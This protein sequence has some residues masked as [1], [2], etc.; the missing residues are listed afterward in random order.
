MEGD[1][2]SSSFSD[3]II[4]V[5][6]LSSEGAK[7]LRSLGDWDESFLVRLLAFARALASR[8]SLDTL[9]VSTV[10]PFGKIWDDLA[11]LLAL[12]LGRRRLS[13]ESRA[14]VLRVLLESTRELRMATSVRSRSSADWSEA[15]FSS[16]RYRPCSATKSWS[17]LYLWPDGDWF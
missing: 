7:L 16:A 9:I 2:D 1:S 6:R 8:S 11:R 4:P 3:A 13:T 10:K 12:L 15:C 5:C 17:V 14:P